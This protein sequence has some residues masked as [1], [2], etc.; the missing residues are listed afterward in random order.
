MED[1]S[2]EGSYSIIA[3]SCYIKRVVSMQTTDTELEI[4]EKTLG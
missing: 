3:H 4:S 2:V 1:L